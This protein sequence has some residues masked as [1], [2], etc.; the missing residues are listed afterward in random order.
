TSAS[1]PARAA[2]PATM[3]AT[4]RRSRRCRASCGAGCA[5]GSGRPSFRTTSGPPTLTACARGT[6]W[7]SACWRLR[8]STSSSSTSSS[9]TSCGRCGWQPAPRSRPSHTT[10]SAAFSS[11]GELCPGLL[12]LCGTPAALGTLCPV[13]GLPGGLQLHPSCASRSPLHCL[14]QLPP[15]SPRAALLPLAWGFSLIPRYLPLVHL[16]VLGLAQSS[17]GSFSSETIMF[18]H[19]IFYQGLKARI[20]SWPTL[21]LGECCCLL[22]LLLLLLLLSLQLHSIICQPAAKHCATAHRVLAR[23]CQPE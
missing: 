6:R 21:V 2:R 22:L 5:G 12:E 18:L 8:P 15:A 17:L 3:T 11:T 9:T 14:E 23:L 16:F 19:Q 10:M 1:R 20:S 4:S 13:P 7:C